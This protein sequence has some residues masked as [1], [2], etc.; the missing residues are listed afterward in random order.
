MDDAQLERVIRRSGYDVRRDDETGS[1]ATS[2]YALRDGKR[3]TR[4]QPNL[5]ALAEYL[6]CVERP[7][8]FIEDPDALERVIAMHA[9]ERNHFV[10]RR[11]AC[12]V[13]IFRR[14]KYVQLVSAAGTAPAMYELRTDG[15]RRTS[16]GNLPPEVVAAFAT[17]HRG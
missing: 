14:Y 5:L 15:L 8:E 16:N 2:V 3:H 13:A 7:L 10:V 4:S 17:A 9:E 12:R 11:A 6:G 1:G